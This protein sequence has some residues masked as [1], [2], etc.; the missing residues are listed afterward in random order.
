[1]AE[2][3]KKPEGWNLD[4][5]ETVIV[6]IFIIAILGAIPTVLSYLDSGEI[7]F[8]GYSV[9]GI[10]DFFINNTWLFR[11]LGFVLAGFGAVASFIYNKKT[12]AIWTAEKAKLYPSDMPATM[13][14]DPLPD[15]LKGRWEKIVEKSNSENQSDWRSAIIDADIILDELLGKLQLPGDTMGEK[16]KAVEPSDF[17]TID[18]AWEA[19]KA[20]NAIAHQGSN[21]LLNQRE[22]RRIISLYGAVFKEFELI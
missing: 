4:P 5:M 10:I 19:H 15:P 1:M 12:D 21:F 3:K 22:T 20:R 8:F 18:L 14:G 11:I 9:N 6:L 16:L 13:V 7:T 2:E 17:V